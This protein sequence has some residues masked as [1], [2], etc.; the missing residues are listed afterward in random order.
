MPNSRAISPMVSRSPLAVTGYV[1]GHAS[2]SD[3]DRDKRLVEL[4]VHES[5]P[6][7]RRP[8]KRHRLLLC[9]GSSPT[10]LRGSYPKLLLASLRLN[11]KL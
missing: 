1:A 2:R 8:V 6:T 5:V 10:A 9:V 11:L 7:L 3:N 4:L